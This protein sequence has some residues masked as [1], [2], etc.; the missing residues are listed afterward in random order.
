VAADLGIPAITAE[1]G[2][3]GILDRT[4]VDRH[5]RGLGNVARFLGLTEGEAERFPAPVEHDGWAWLRSE[6][7]GWWQPAVDTGE[8]VDEGA[9]LGTVAPILGGDPVEIHAPA[10]GVPLFITSSPAVAANGLLMG[11]ALT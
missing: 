11:L 1:S 3:C 9:L 5:L 4:A 2:Q 10:A 8:Q 7:P 6:V